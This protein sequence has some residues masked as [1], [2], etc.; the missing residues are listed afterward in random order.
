MMDIVHVQSGGG[1]TPTPDVLLARLIP[2]TII[3]ENI[4]NYTVLELLQMGLNCVHEVAHSVYIKHVYNGTFADTFLGAELFGA[5]RT[6]PIEDRV[7]NA[8]K[9]VQKLT[10]I[11]KATVGQTGRAGYSAKGRRGGRISH[12]GR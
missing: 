9:R 8:A 10:T 12:G 3:V 1:S 4:T 6:I 11:S 5:N 7:D 2:Y